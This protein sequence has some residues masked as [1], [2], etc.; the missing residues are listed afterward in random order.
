MRFLI[1]LGLL[2][3]A[4]AARAA[5]ERRS[6]YDDMRPE[7]RAM[8]DDE[9]ANPGML[10]VM[11]GG[12]LWRRHGC[13]ACHAQ[14]KGVATRYPLLDSKKGLVNLEQRINLCRTDRQQAA[15]FAY[16]SRELL[17]LTAFVA[18][19]SRGQPIQAHIGARGRRQQARHDSR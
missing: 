7:T 13:A 5:D 15:P 11:E 18:N 19:Q 12:Q 16:E 2:V 4:Q 10:A 8:Q 1:L 9:L 3:L 6:G 14:M 17:A